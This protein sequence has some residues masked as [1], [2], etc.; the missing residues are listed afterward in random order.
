MHKVSLYPA[1]NNYSG[2]DIG[3]YPWDA[4]VYM[5]FMNINRV[6]VAINVNY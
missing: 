5:L 3:Y 4:I 6:L 1:I 2:K